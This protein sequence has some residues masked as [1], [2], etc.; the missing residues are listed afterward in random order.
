MQ[1][2]FVKFGWKILHQI[3]LTTLQKKYRSKYLKITVVKKCCIWFLI[4]QFSKTLFQMF[5]FDWF[6]NISIQILIQIPFVS[7]K[8]LTT[9]NNFTISSRIVLSLF[10]FPWTIF[11]CWLITKKQTQTWGVQDNMHLQIGSYKSIKKMLKFL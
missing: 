7:D 4:S 8:I 10:P 5:S 1:F 3:F 6:Q 11:F 9:S 2:V